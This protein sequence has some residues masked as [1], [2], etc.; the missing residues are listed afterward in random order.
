MTHPEENKPEWNAE[1]INR[2]RGST[3]FK[4][5][6]WC[7][8]SLGVSRYDCTLHGNCNLQSYHNEV[9]WHEECPIVHLGKGDLS[10]EMNTKEW[11][12]N[13]DLTSIERKKSQITQLAELRKRATDKP[14]LS[15][16]RKA[17]HFNVGNRVAVYIKGVDKDWKF[18]TVVDGC[19]HHDGCVSFMYDKHP[20][21]EPFGGG[22]EHPSIMLESEWEWFSHNLEDFARWLKSSLEYMNKGKITDYPIPRY[23]LREAVRGR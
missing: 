3:D 5:C 22:S 11:E 23:S 10:A 21:K 20:G 13:I 12:I 6:G 4:T 15:H 18:G 9:E 16:N 8:H 7:S 17:E 2:K 1:N 14:P 19:R